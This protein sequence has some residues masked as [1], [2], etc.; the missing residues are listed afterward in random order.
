MPALPGNYHGE[1][2]H[3]IS[4]NTKTFS[5][6]IL[7][8]NNEH[9]TAGRRHHGR[10]RLRPLRR[11]R[12]RATRGSL[13]QGAG[14]TGGENRMNGSQPSNTY[15]SVFM[16]KDDGK[17]YLVGTDN[18]ELND[19]DIWDI[20]DPDEAEAG[21][22]VRPAGGLP[23]DLPDRAAPAA[24]RDLPPRH[25]REGDQRP[26]GHARLLLGR[27]ATCSWTSRTRRRR[28]TSA[29]PTS[30]TRIR[31]CRASRRPRATPTRP[32]SRTTTR[33]SSA[34]TR[35][36]IRTARTSSSSNDQERPA[37]EVGG[38][39]SPASLPDQ[40]LSGKG[41]YG[42]YGCPADPTTLPLAADYTD[43]ELGL[44]PG[45]ERILAAAARSV[46][47][48]RRPTTTATAT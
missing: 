24:E 4:V 26:S 39:T 9:A 32:S 22:R 28:P 46:R 33:T 18:E 35:T 2:A 6:D 23:A 29:T 5:G 36:S 7:A 37:V 17:V 10:R 19:V 25:G 38:G 42:G 1:G 15:H 40:T 14:D 30:R 48:I 31:S 27:A 3:V 8:V 11:E 41:V 13:V 21:R 47:T 43:A 44:Q 16:W 20:T 12:T 34:R 45:D